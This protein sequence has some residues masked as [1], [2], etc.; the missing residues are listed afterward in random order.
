MHLASLR[1]SSRKPIEKASPKRESKRSRIFSLSIAFTHA[2]THSLT[3]LIKLLAA[4]LRRR[5]RRRHQLLAACS[6]LENPSVTLFVV[7]IIFSAISL[8]SPCATFSPHREPTGRQI[9][10]EMMTDDIMFHESMNFS[11]ASRGGQSSSSPKVMRSEE[12][13]DLTR[14]EN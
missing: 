14:E 9:R 13:S 11:T 7:E 12:M 2:L 3:D 6:L 8:L 1:D 4:V 10:R 5:R